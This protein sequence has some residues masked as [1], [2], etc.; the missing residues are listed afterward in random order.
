MVVPLGPTP[1]PIP[2]GGGGSAAGGLGVAAG[3]RGGVGAGRGGGGGVCG[4]GS[5]HTTQALLADLQAA[6]SRAAP[7]CSGSGRAAPVC[8]GTTSHEQKT[9]DRT[10]AACAS[11][12]ILVVYSPTQFPVASHMPPGHGV[13]SVAGGYTQLPWLQQLPWGQVVVV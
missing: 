9:R 6:W 10:H 1:K 3:Q 7:A 8:C 11:T 12:K 13:P 5:A 4:R 2:G